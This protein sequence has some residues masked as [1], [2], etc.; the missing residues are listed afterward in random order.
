M[1]V[2][3]AVTRVL[4]LVSRQSN[5]LFNLVLCFSLRPVC[6]VRRNKTNPDSKALSTKWPWNC[7]SRPASATRSAHIIHHHHMNLFA[8][9]SRDLYRRSRRS[10]LT[11]KWR[12]TYGY[13]TPFPQVLGPLLVA[14]TYEALYGRSPLSKVKGGLVVRD[15]GIGW[16]EKGPQK[17]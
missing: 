10:S 5:F 9:R 1:S 2:F 11:Q 14:V 15:E 13:L 16:V 6:V 7:T 12:S 17:G 3:Q 4:Q 8:S